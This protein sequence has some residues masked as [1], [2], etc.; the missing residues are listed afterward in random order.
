MITLLYRTGPVSSIKLQSR[1]QKHFKSGGLL[2]ALVA[3]PLLL[4]FPHNAEAYIGPGA[5]LGAIGTVVALVFALILLV[6]GFVWYPVKRLF[7][8][9][10]AVNPPGK[11]DKN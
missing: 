1:S 2:A 3:L 10:K 4:S 8:R 5:G 6:V 11:D 9:R 7:R